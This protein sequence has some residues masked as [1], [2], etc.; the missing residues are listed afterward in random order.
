MQKTLKHNC[1]IGVDITPLCL[2]TGDMAK[3]S[4]EA[5]E[6]FAECGRK[7]RGI[8]KRYT[9]AELARRTAQL[10]QTRTHRI[11]QKRLKTAGRKAGNGARGGKV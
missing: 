5:R 4:Q 8:P 3:L 2:H 6:F 1:I 9:K 11:H 7:A 10:R